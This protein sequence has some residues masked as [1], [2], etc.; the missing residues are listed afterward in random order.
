MMGQNM[1]LM[2][3][4]GMNAAPMLAAMALAIPAF[5]KGAQRIVATRKLD[6]RIE[7]Y[8]LEDGRIVDRDEGLRLAR[9]GD[10]L[11]V[12]I[13]NREGR[14]YLKSLPDETEDNNLDNLPPIK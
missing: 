6:G 13:A 9:L 11:G 1:G 12:G 4:Q 3:E 8:Q 14:E 10:I 5:N 7:G 2:T